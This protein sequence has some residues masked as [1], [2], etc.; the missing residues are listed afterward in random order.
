MRGIVTLPPHYAVDA[1]AKHGRDLIVAQA[2][3]PA[4]INV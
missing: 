4:K 3:L 2:A 1:A